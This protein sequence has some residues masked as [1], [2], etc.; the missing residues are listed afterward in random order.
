MWK[1]LGLYDTSI[2]SVSFVLEDAVA[3]FKLYY[4]ACQAFSYSFWCV[5]L[6]YTK[7]FV[8]ELGHYHTIDYLYFITAHN[9]SRDILIASNGGSRAGRFW[10]YSNTVGCSSVNVSRLW[11]VIHFGGP[12]LNYIK[13]RE[14]FTQYRIVVLW[15]IKYVLLTNWHTKRIKASIIRILACAIISKKVAIIVISFP[16]IFFCYFNINFHCQVG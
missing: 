12:V 11:V 9:S 15:L 16:T 8:V 5:L 7:R 2:V 1:I 6:V 10:V 3:I 13:R 4:I 14:L